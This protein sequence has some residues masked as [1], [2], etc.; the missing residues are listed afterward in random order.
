MRHQAE[1]EQGRQEADV[2]AVESSQSLV[3]V[4]GP[5][6]DDPLDTAVKQPVE[7][8]RVVKRVHTLFGDDVVVGLGSENGRELRP[9]RAQH[10]RAM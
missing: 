7:Q 8:P 10:S 9:P 2:E 5:A 1:D 6:D 3:A 4:V